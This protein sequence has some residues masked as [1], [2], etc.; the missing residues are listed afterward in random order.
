MRFSEIKT[1]VKAHIDAGDTQTVIH[2][3]GSPGCG[4]SALGDEIGGEM[5]F[6]KVVT[7]NLS[8]L[9]I[10]DVAGLY[11]PDKESGTLKF[12]A[13]PVLTQL[14]TGR[15]FLVIDEFADA[16][17]QMQNMGRRIS[18]AREINGVKL[19]PETFILA[20]S[21]R[22]IDKSGAG[23]LSGKVKNAVSQLTMES[24]LDDFVDWAMRPNPNTVHG[25]NIDPVEI[26][27]LRF[28]PN[29]LDMYN[30][31]AETSPTPRQWELVS[32]VPTSLP[33]HLFH[34]DVA[35]KVGAGPAAE[36]AAFRK[37]YESL[38]SFEEVVMNPTGV[39]I[40]KDLSAQYA[41]VGSVAH[42]TTPSNIER[43]A[44]FVERLPASFGVMFWQDAIKK[45]PAIKTTKPFISWA[46]GSGNIVLN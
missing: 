29:L 33:L 24:N 41:I 13:S 23:K 44:K 30:A 46:T 2:I 15:N 21:N 22:S 12:H 8:M 45:T 25:C 31:D 40:P 36:Y 5:G 18:W 3:A 43:V 14:Q 39:A 1:I 32:R 10:P 17:I 34:A 6:D 20:M 11:F 38:V 4:K 27:F 16:N 7:V 42:N 28:K 37:I 19:S 35:S 9:D 26:Q